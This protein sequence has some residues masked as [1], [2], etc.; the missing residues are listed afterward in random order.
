VWCGGGS[1]R[2]AWGR[3]DSCKLR[4]AK[5]RVEEDRIGQYRVV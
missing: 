3:W 5:G 4:I 2:I 1:C